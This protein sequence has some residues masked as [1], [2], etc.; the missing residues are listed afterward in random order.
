MNKLINERVATLFL[1]TDMFDSIK[2]DGITVGRDN[3]I[4]ESKDKTPITI[5][6]KDVLHSEIFE[7]IKL[8]IFA[9]ASHVECVVLLTKAHK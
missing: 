5:S 2:L 3:V 7:S 9:Q 4:I 1:F 8:D 6:K